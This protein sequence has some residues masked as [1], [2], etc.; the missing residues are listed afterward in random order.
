MP[1]DA[2]QVHRLS[3]QRTELTLYQKAQILEARALG[4]TLTQI[5]VQL[6]IPRST[7]ATFLD[8]ALR[9]KSIDNLSRSGRPRATSVR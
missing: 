7:I 8:R 4:K 6:G 2:P 5:H 3:S 1:I 9:R